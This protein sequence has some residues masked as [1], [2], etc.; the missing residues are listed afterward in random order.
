ME[1]HNI[2]FFIEDKNQSDF[3]HNS[4]GTKI[5]LLFVNSICQL[6]SISLSPCIIIYEYRSGDPMKRTIFNKLVAQ[7]FITI[8]IYNMTCA[9]FLQVRFFSGKVFGYN[10]TLWAFE[11]PKTILFTI[12]VLIIYEYMILR[13]L[14][15]RIWKRAPPPINEDFMA[16]YLAMMNVCLAT[17]WGMIQTSGHIMAGELIYMLTGVYPMDLPGM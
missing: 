13:Y 6:V 14:C 8:F 2:T 16:N 9:T 4:P 7:I 11:V 5:G 12:G 17:F 15:I 1:F 10:F 3:F